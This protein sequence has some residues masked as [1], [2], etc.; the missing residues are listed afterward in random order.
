MTKK[1]KACVLCEETD[2]DKLSELHGFSV[3]KGCE[4]VLGLLKDETI[5][6]HIE[7]YDKAKKKSPNKATFEQEI[8]NRLEFL[9]KDYV[10][11]K[12]K[13]LHIIERLEHLKRND[14]V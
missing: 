10:K 1:A 14:G 13:L 6:R 3:C 11:K 5:K 4:S 7:T 9:Y 2:K 12:I 8:R